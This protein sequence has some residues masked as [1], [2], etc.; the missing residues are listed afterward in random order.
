MSRLHAEQFRLPLLGPLWGVVRAGQADEQ[1]RLSLGFAPSW[2]PPQ[3]LVLATAMQHHGIW[4]TEVVQVLPWPDVDA[5]ADGSPY[6]VQSFDMK[7]SMWRGHAALTCFLAY[8]FDGLVDIRRARLPWPQTVAPSCS[9]TWPQRWHERTTPGTCFVVSSCQYPSGLLDAAPDAHH[10]LP[11]PADASFARLQGWR[12]QAG[13]V[14]PAFG[15][16]LGDQVYVDAT[17]GM[18]DPQALGDRYIK[19]YLAQMQRSYRND[20]LRNLPLLCLPDDHELQNDWQPAPHTRIGPARQQIRE[21]GLAQYWHFQRM[22]APSPQVWQSFERHGASFFMADTRTERSART[23]ATIDAARIMEPDQQRAL[24]QW[25]ADQG[26]GAH[27]K[28]LACPSAVLPRHTAVDLSRPA[29][30][31][32]SDGWDGYPQSLFQLL[33]AL[34][35]HEVQNL[36][37]LSGDEHIASLARISVQ[38]LAHPGQAPTSSPYPAV[39]MHA[40]H[41]SGWYSPF[42]FAN[43]SPADLR[44]QDHFAFSVGETHTLRRHY[45]CTVDTT[46]YPGDGCVLVQTTPSAQV[47]CRFL[48]GDP[49]VE[50]PDWITL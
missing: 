33:S 38:R 37:M 20:A 21:A 41:A 46:F 12:Q 43:A 27:P 18:F 2:G 50:P 48:K 3:A 4:Q 47:Q 36:V 15:L 9:L 34:C 31:L 1:I 32:R 49:R 24:T 42:P 23:A 13:Q 11:G 7:P 10:W 39:Q 17:A 44:G 30:A 25:I 28:F 29:S 6:C 35:D 26:P 19:P 8:G 5:S 22:Q 16:L 14:Q 45:H 40:V